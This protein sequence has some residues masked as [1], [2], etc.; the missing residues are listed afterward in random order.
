MLSFQFSVLCSAVHTFG[1]NRALKMS[2]RGRR[3][4]KHQRIIIFSWFLCEYI[5]VCVQA[6]I[7]QS[8]HGWRSIHQLSRLPVTS[9][10]LW[11]PF[12]CISNPPKLIHSPCKS[13]ETAR[14]RCMQLYVMP[15]F[16]PCSW[17]YPFKVLPLQPSD[18]VDSFSEAWQILGQLEHCLDW[19]RRDCGSYSHSQA[20]LCCLLV[21]RAE[22]VLPAPKPCCAFWKAK[23][24]NCG[25]HREREGCVSGNIKGTKK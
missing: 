21:Y 7:R 20:G 6:L 4:S 24:I 10:H 18:K 12:H 8:A 14:W 25:R 16:L 19:G 15:A 3:T 1:Q 23:Q 22:T 11:G 13:N 9:G 2:P 5:D 17:N